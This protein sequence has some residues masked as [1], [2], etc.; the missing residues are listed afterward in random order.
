[1]EVLEIGGKLFNQQECRQITNEI[2]ACLREKGLT[3]CQAEYFLD[4][5]KDEIKKVVV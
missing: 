3:V 2:I 1:M 4:E 5:V